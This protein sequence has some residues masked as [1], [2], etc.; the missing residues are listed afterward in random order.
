VLVKRSSRRALR[1][2]RSQP[3]GRE[4]TVTAPA[5][6]WPLVSRPP[7]RVAALLRQSTCILL[8]AV[9]RSRAAV[10]RTSSSCERRWRRCWWTNGEKRSARRQSSELSIGSAACLA[11]RAAA[12][13]GRQ[14]FDLPQTA[15]RQQPSPPRLPHA[16]PQNA[17]QSSEAR[18]EPLFTN[19]KR[20]VRPAGSDA[21]AFRAP[22]ARSS[23]QDGRPGRRPPARPTA[24]HPR[25]ETRTVSLTPLTLPPAQLVHLPRSSDTRSAAC[26]SRPPC[27]S[28]TQPCLNIGP[29]HAVADKHASPIDCHQAR[30]PASVRPW[31]P[32]RRLAEAIRLAD[33][34]VT[35]PS[36]DIA[37]LPVV[38][39]ACRRARLP[40]VSRST[41]RPTE[42]SLRHLPSTSCPP[43]QLPRLGAS[44]LTTLAPAP[45]MA[46][47]HSEEASLHRL[48]SSSSSSPEAA[49]GPSSAFGP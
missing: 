16:L 34:G 15:G 38:P 20:H 17:I 29:S 49:G 19:G 45:A 37:H 26:P 12:P 2:C 14:R 33:R 27:E 23:S 5:A 42:P 47:P 22:M 39:S 13:S 21:R 36:A 32:S 25:P 11:A 28:A 24:C 10:Q 18:P 3:H 7:R 31:Q 35:P 43:R 9:P 4:L 1:R 30:S 40:L 41:A 44:R 46:M 8:S 48:S 6:P